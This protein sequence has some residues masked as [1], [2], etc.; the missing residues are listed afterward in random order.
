MGSVNV[1][2]AENAEKLNIDL[3]DFFDNISINQ[4]EN[5]LKAKYVGKSVPDES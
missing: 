5:K 1:T 2:A 3:K 4:I